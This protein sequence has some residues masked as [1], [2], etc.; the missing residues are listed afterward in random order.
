[1][2]GYAPLLGEQCAV[3][4]SLSSDIRMITIPEHSSPITISDVVVL[5]TL[6]TSMNSGLRELYTVYPQDLVSFINKLSC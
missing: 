5:N 4:I 3:Y 6:Q 2:H 1:M